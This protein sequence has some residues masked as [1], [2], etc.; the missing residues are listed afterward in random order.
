MNTMY[1]SIQ[2][3]KDTYVYPTNREDQWWKYNQIKLGLGNTLTLFFITLFWYIIVDEHVL[4]NYFY[5]SETRFLIHLLVKLMFHVIH[6]FLWF[7]SWWMCLTEVSYGTNNCV[8][9]WTIGDSNGDPCT[10]LVHYCSMDATLVLPIAQNLK[11][12]K[13]FYE[14]YKI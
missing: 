10:L 13:L 8:G 6:I 1:L 14:N 4:S 2:P 5:L 9:R 11:K 7:I 3:I 12:R